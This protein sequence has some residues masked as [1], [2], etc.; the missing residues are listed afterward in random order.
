MQNTPIGANKISPRE[1]QFP[2]LKI[3]YLDPVQEMLEGYDLTKVSKERAIRE[4]H[5]IYKRT[6]DEHAKILEK[7]SEQKGFI[8]VGDLV[9]FKDIDRLRKD[10]PRFLERYYRVLERYG[11]QLIL[12][13]VHCSSEIIRA[14]VKNVKRI[15]E[16][17][18]QNRN[19]INKGL[20]K[21]L[22]ENDLTDLP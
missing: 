10:Q 14:H 1:L 15:S 21:A 13:N 12:L 9:T 22:E 6:A 20:L 7:A 8:K 4:I 3:G 11:Y 18:N 2:N 17:P 19:Q 16:I 5:A